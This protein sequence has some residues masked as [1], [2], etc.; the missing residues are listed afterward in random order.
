[1]HHGADDHGLDRARFH[2]V[3]RRRAM[4]AGQHRQAASE[5][6]CG[7]RQDVGL[8]FR[9]CRA[10]S[11]MRGGRR[12]HDHGR[13][14]RRGLPTPR[15]RRRRPA[16]RRSRWR[17]VRPGGGPR[18]PGHAAPPRVRRE[19]GLGQGVCAERRRRRSRIA[20]VLHP[21]RDLRHRAGRR[22]SYII[23]ARTVV[24]CLLRQPADERGHRPHAERW[25]LEEAIGFQLQRALRCWHERDVP[26]LRLP[27]VAG[28]LS[29]SLLRPDS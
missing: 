18:E 14:H 12:G 7:R 10:H 26:L 3:H 11:A 25:P 15:G 23:A 24:V 20:G 1:M 27:S 28:E 17:R 22:R 2:G 6:Q 5:N 29:A 13:R 19:C 4:A 9:P 21:G 16:A 8:H